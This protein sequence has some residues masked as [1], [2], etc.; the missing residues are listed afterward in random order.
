MA[1]ARSVFALSAL[2]V[3]ATTVAAATQTNEKP[4][5]CVCLGCNSDSRAP[6]WTGMLW[7][8]FVF[9]CLSCFS[10]PMLPSLLLF[11]IFHFF[12]ALRRN[13]SYNFVYARAYEKWPIIIQKSYCTVDG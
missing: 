9:L 7:C 5:L 10:S 2:L 8:V 12:V 6:A 11:P 13:I 3:A 1:R 4:V